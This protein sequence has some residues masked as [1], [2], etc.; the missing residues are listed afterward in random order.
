MSEDIP[1]SRGIIA[2]LDVWLSILASPFLPLV[3]IPGEAG[4]FHWEF[5]EK[6]PETLMVGK[7]VRMVSGIKASLLLADS[8]FTTECASLLRMVSEFSQEIISVGEGIVEGRL[9]KTQQRFIQQY[10]APLA[11]NPE[12]LE[13][14]E[15]ARY[16]SREELYKAHY[17]LWAKNSREADKM[18]RQSRFLNYT[19]DKYVHGAYLTAMEL[20]N[21]YDNSFVLDGHDAEEPKDSVRTSVAGKLHEVI[22]ALEIMSSFSDNVGLR[23]ELREARRVLDASQEY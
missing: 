12:E 18:R 14:S 1:I 23:Q 21:G 2:R 7:A 11:T 9:T 3:R 19:Y 22:F 20:Y 17:R 6:R 16:V 10:F 13:K 4:R 8:G 5:P 15:K